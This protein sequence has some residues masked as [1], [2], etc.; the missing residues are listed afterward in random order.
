MASKLEKLADHNCTLCELHETTERVCVMGRGKPKSRIIIIGEAPGAAEEETGEPFRGAAGKL[1]DQAIREAGLADMDPY[2]TNAVKCR[3]PDN[4]T[5]DRDEWESCSDYLRQEIA[6][7]D[8]KG[9]LLLGNVAL[10]AV[11]GVSG[12]T[13][14]RGVPLPL[15]NKMRDHGIT[16]DMHVMATVH[17]AY[18]LRNPGQGP[19][20]NEDVKRFRRLMD[21]SLQAVEVKV[22]AVTTESAL[23]KVCAYL[24]KQ[25]VLAYDVEN[26]DAPWTNNRYSDATGLSGGWGIVCLGISADGETTFVIPL[27][28]PDSP[29]RKRWKRLLREYVKP[30]LEQPGVKLVAQNGKH[31]NIQ[32]AGAGV[33]VEHTFDVMLAAH[34]LDENRPKNLGFLSQTLLGADVYKGMVDT[35]PEKIMLSDM[36]DMMRYNGIDVGYTYQLREK[37]IPELQQHPRLKR[38]FTRLMMPASNMIQQVEYRGMYINK[39]R[40]FKRIDELQDRID[41]ALAVLAEHGAGE[42]NPNSPQQLGRWL[43]SSKKKGGLGLNPLELTA[44]GNPSTR[45]AVLLN[46]RDHPAIRA[47]LR[48]R[49]LQLKWMNTCLLPWA[50]RLDDRSRI[51]TTYKLYGTVTGRISGDLQQVPRDPFIR[52]VFG[53]PDGWRFIQADYSQIELRIAAHCAQERRMIRAFQLNEDLH[54]ATAVALT[55]KPTE[56]VDKEERK[57]A[58]A[59]NFGFLYGM[60]PKKFQAYAFENYDL[61]V[62]MAEA[63]LARDQYFSMFPDLRAWHERQERLVRSR[64]WVQ[65]PIG[66]VRHLPDVYSPDGGVQREAIRQAINSPVQGTASD[67]M[68]FGMVQLQ[69]VLDPHE[70]YMVGTLHDGIFFECREDKLDKWGPIIKSTLENLPLKETFLT[71]LSVPIVCDVEYG[72]HWGEVEATL[73]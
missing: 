39:K 44:T 22:K 54:M 58:K 42:I 37:L 62:T 6:A 12:I 16:S 25:P 68:L 4:R 67:L 30:I 18:V 52:T 8:P 2:I 32:L 15:T 60:Y 43:Y 72:Q 49:T 69:G 59:V 70:C 73:A 24:A 7:V 13:S 36:K 5:P 21:G 45:E 9:V 34:L 28:H 50:G 53:A 1:L 14:K 65:S 63:E 38:I 57:K 31:D 27:L 40:L 71:E 56:Q 48:Y 33:F 17:P 20:F 35:K 61:R 47:L 51:H 29:F 41:D 55:G 19:M 26:R 46:Y 64:G 3:P 23:K 11:Y 66:R 10:R